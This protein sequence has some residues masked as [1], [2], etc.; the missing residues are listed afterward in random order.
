MDSVQN[1]RE[2]FMCQEFQLVTLRPNVPVF[3]YLPTVRLEEVQEVLAR[4]EETTR[5]GSEGSESIQRPVLEL[6]AGPRVGPSCGRRGKVLLADDLR[7]KTDKHF[8]AYL[9]SAAPSWSCNWREASRIMRGS[10]VVS[11]SGLGPG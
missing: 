10:T 6:T 2:C 1:T 11:V 5:K 9:G 3:D 4:S 7:R 8:P